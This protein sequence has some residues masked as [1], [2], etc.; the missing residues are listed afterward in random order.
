MHWSCLLQVEVLEVFAALSRLARKAIATVGTQCRAKG[1]ARLTIGEAFVALPPET[2]LTR[3]TIGVAETAHTRIEIPPTVWSRATTLPPFF[4]TTLSKLLQTRH[5]CSPR[6]AF[7]TPLVCAVSKRALWF[8]ASG[9]GAVGV[10]RGDGY[11]GTSPVRFGV[12]LPLPQDPVPGWRRAFAW[13]RKGA[14]VS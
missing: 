4:R 6:C 14:S 10:F 8:E 9:W 7:L 3:G 13:D 2:F 5:S 11:T 12:H 1:P